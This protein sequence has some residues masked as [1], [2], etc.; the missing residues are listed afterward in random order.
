MVKTW[1]FFFEGHCE[2][3]KLNK[4]LKNEGLFRIKN[5]VYIRS[6]SDTVQMYHHAIQEIFL[7][8]DI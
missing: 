1:Q 8:C 3:S 2:L 5:L 4:G 7:P 6:L